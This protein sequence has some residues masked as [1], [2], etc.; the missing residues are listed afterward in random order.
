MTGTFFPLTVKYPT[1]SNERTMKQSTNNCWW[2]AQMYYSWTILPAATTEYHTSCSYT[3]SVRFQTTVL[4]CHCLVRM[5]SLERRPRWTTSPASLF[6]LS[7]AFDHHVVTYIT[8]TPVYQSVHCQNKLGVVTS[9]RY[10]YYTYTII[11]HNNIDKGN[12]YYQYST[13]IF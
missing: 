12:Q 8:I 3:T 9:K 7:A 6:D 10:L 4:L 13:Y 5:T 1:K 11:I 2:W